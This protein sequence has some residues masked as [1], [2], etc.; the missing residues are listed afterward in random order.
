[1]QGADFQLVVSDLLIPLSL[2]HGVLGLQK[3]EL[4]APWSGTLSSLARVSEGHLDA[5]AISG[6][7]LLRLRRDLY[8]ALCR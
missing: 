3:R 6:R 1:M 7:Q 4:C 8:L 2:F 5:P